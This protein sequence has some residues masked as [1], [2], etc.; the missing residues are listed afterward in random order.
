MKMRTRRQRFNSRNTVV[1]FAVPEDVAAY[2]SM[3]SPTARAD[4]I[5]K[6]I[7]YV[8]KRSKAR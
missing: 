4:L 8:Y 2:L 3:L 5:R 1:T 6:A 7:K